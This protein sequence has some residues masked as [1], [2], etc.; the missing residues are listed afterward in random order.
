VRLPR[1]RSARQI[2]I[3]NSTF[4]TRTG[5]TKEELAGKR[6]Q[7]LLTL[8][9]RIYFETHFAPLLR[10]QGHSMKLRSI[11]STHSASDCLSW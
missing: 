2:S 5:F 11:W 8:P 7:E 3:A 1:H 9:A 10:M 4:C 6:F